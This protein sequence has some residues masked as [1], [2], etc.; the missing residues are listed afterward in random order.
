[1][2]SDVQKKKASGAKNA[3]VFKEIQQKE[4]MPKCVA[5]KVSFLCS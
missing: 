5:A 2:M 3:K 4:K 1:M